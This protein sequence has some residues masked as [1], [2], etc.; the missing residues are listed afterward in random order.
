M[1]WTA[2]VDLG[3]LSTQ[4]LLTDGTAR[5]RRS[6]DTFMGG[7]SLSATG[8]LRAERIS[9]EALGRVA[10]ALRGFR[11]LI[12]E[13]GADVRVVATA[14]ARRA[15]NGDDLT[16]VVRAELDRQ[17]VVIGGSDEA[18]LSFVGA[19]SDAGPGSAAERIVTVDIGGGSTEFA[20]GPASGSARGPD[21]VWSMPIGGSLLTRTYI[22]SDPPRPE[23]LSAA[24]TV[25]ELHLDDLERELPDLGPAITDATVLA[26]GGAVTVAAVEVGLGD[27][28]PLNGDGDGPLHGFELTRDAVEDV[29]RTVATECRADRA[30]NPGLPSSRVDEIVG[31]CA[32]LVGTMRQLGLDAVRISQRGLADGIV[33]TGWRP[34]V[35]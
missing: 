3:S 31:G 24:L 28:D 33:A 25:L 27:A 4:L 15:T 7:T 35:G 30:H 18:R 2:V 6:V 20:I 14:A 32:L 26:L 9:D 17:L 29:F 1:S 13:R 10:E 34:P 22:R 11:A 19:C 21:A 8:E 23:E 12:D 5:V 16:A